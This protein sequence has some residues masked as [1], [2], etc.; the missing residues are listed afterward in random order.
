MA[1]NQDQDSLSAIPYERISA[2]FAEQA[3]SASTMSERTGERAP[4]RPVGVIRRHVSPGFEKQRSKSASQKAIAAAV[5][6][7]KLTGPVRQKDKFVPLPDSGLI[8]GLPPAEALIPTPIQ[9]EDALLEPTVG[10]ITVYCIAESLDRKALELTLRSSAPASALHVYQESLHFQTPGTGGTTGD[11]FFFE[12]GVVACWGLTA[13]QEHSI[14]KRL[15]GLCQRQP[16]P[17][18]EVEKDEYV[19]KMSMTEPPHIQNDTF[20]INKR[21][22]RDHEV[23]LAISHAL[24][25]SSKLGVYEDRVIRLVHQTK[26]LPEALAKQGT[27][28]ISRKKVAQLIGKVFLQSSA[29]NLL[30]TVLD[31]PDFFWSRPD[32]LQG[33]YERASEYL[34]LET[35]VEVLNARFQVL[36]EMLDMLRDHQNNHHTQRLEWIIIALIAVDLVVLVFQLLSSFGYLKGK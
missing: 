12:Y 17:P 13:S 4:D 29:V 15:G 22:G 23:K 10:R 14:V 35:R 20:T 2:D 24:A 3:P 34:E 32:H 36:Q 25:Q 11:V 7:G 30:S 8:V 33:L 5:A 21:Q 26:H 1:T 6:P 27:V 31:T 16:L 19:F 9:E 28:H 18:D